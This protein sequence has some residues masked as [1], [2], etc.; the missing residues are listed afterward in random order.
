MTPRS[1]ACAFSASAIGLLGGCS[2]SPFDQPYDTNHSLSRTLPESADPAAR[3]RLGEDA[4]QPELT[5]T[6]SPDDYIRYAL[7]H[8]PQVEAAYQR[9]RAAAERLPQV[10]A[11]P[12]PRL[13]FGFFLDEV[14][15]RTGAQQGRIG[16]QQSFPWPGQLGAREDAA[17][18]GA[19]AAWRRFEAARLTVAERVVTTLHDLAYL[20]KTIGITRENLDLLLSFEEVLRAR[21]RVGASSHPE[22]IR[23]Q[24]E[25][26]QL[27]DRIAQL[28]AMR[29]AYVAE[30]NSVLDRP[31]STAVPLMG[32][33]PGRVASVDAEGLAA[34][35]RRANPTLLALDEQMEAQRFLTEVA[36]KDGLPDFTVGVDYIVTNDAAG[37]SFPESG[38]DPILLRFGLSLPVWR[39]KYDAGVRESIARR[40]AIAGDRHAE[41]NRIAAGIHRAWFEHTDADRRVKLYELTLIP[42]AE[43]SLRASLAGFRAGDTSFLDLLDTERTLLEF[44]IAAERARADRGKALARLNTLVG[45]S[46]P[47]DGTTGEETPASPT[48][49]GQP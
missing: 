13:S 9:W 42:K 36:R 32:T 16:V 17:S 22:V 12:D 8:S 33:L 47:T 5:E 39:E 44:S 40:L 48:E 18:R 45:A 10:S 46:V 24:V 38:D 28:D 21:Y 49:G 1:V 34:I 41:A 20:D 29:P 27:E 30:L 35:A 2:S 15:T 25:L 11:L 26:G 31:G 19:S 23:V 3:A 14:E 4:P 43:E 37:A 6:S 7:F